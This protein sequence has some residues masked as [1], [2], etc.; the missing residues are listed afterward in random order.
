[1]LD[2]LVHLVDPNYDISLGDPWNKLLDISLDAFVL[3]VTLPAKGSTTQPTVSLSYSPG[4]DLGFLDV[5]TIT[6]TYSKPP[7][8]SGTSSVKIAIEGRF[9]GQPF[10]GNSGNPPLTWDAMN[11][12]PPSIPGKGAQLFD[13]EYVGLGQHVALSGPD[14][15][16]VEKVMA[17]LR[18]SVIPVQAGQLPPFG[19]AGGISFSADS[20]WL[21]G[22]QFTVMDTVAIAGIFNDPNLY[23]ILITLSG[24]KAK[25]FAGLRF[26]ILYRKVTDSIGV[27][28][29]EFTL[30]DEMRH[31]EFGEVSITLPVLVLDIYTNGNF[32]ID[33]GFPTGLDFSNSF[34]IQVFPFLGYGGFYFALLDGATSSRVPQIGN[35]SFSPVIEF[36]IALSLGVGK[37]VDEGILKGG[38]SVTVVGILQGVLGWF[39]PSDSSPKDTY[40]GIQGTVS[41]VG[42]LYATIDFAIIQASVDVTAYISVTLTIESY[43]PIYIEAT[44]SVSVRVSVK[45]VFF[46]I[47]CSFSATVDASFTIGSAGTPPWKVIPGGASPNV[48][49]GRLRGQMTLHSPPPRH[50]RYLK[51]LRRSLASTDP[52]ITTWPALCVLPQGKQTVTIWAMPSFTKSETQRGGV[53]AVLLL[54][55]ENSIHPGA[56][57]LA[58]HR[59]L[60]GVDPASAPFN[61]LME[62][63]LRWGIHVVTSG[64]ANVTADQLEGLRKQLHN[65]DTVAAAFDYATLTQFLAQNFVF[66]IAPSADQVPSATIAPAPSGASRTN[67]ITTVTTT[68][69]HGFA[70]GDTV[71]VS[72]VADA[73]FDGTGPFTIVAPVTSTSLAYQQ[74][75]QPDSTSGGGTVSKAA[76]VAI[77]PM[78]PEI[79]LTDTTGTHVA[80]NGFNMVDT[81]YQAKA[82]AYFQLLQVQF[83][84]LDAAGSGSPSADLLP[85]ADPGVSMATIIFSRYFNMLMSAGVKA[86]I[87]LL[88][89]Y[90]YVIGPAPMSMSDI[91]A[92]LS[93]NLIDDPLQ[94][95]APNQ[96]RAVL[97]AGARLSLP[98][99]MHQVRL[100]ESFATIAAALGAGALDAGGKPYSAAVLIAANLDSPGIFNTG[101]ATWPIAAQTGALRSGGT[102]TIASA[103]PHGLVPGN[104]VWVSGVTDPTFNG[105]YR[106]TAV[107][108][109]TTFAYV[110]T[111]QPDGTSQGGTATTTISVQV[112][113]L[114][115]TSQANETLG[116]IA[117]RLLLRAAGP[118]LIATISGLSEAAQTLLKIPANADIPN[119]NA[120]IDPTKIPAVALPTGPPYVVVAG[121]TLTLVAAY[122]LAIAQKVLNT[123][124]FLQALAQ[125]NPALPIDPSAPLTAGTAIA[126]PP[127]I[128]ECQAGDTIANVAVTLIASASALQAALAEVPGGLPLLAPQAVLKAPLVYEVQPGDTFSGIA[129]RLDLTLEDVA[130]GA[131]QAVAL[132]A[133]NQTVTIADLAKIPVDTL[134][135]GS[136]VGGGQ[137]SGLL[138]QAEWNKAS[139][140]VSRFLLSGLRLPDPNDPVFQALT[141]KDLQDPTK[142]GGI[143]TKPMFALTGQQYPFANSATS[144]NYQITLA[145]PGAASW[146]TF[147]SGASAIFSLTDG[148]SDLLEKIASTPLDPQMQQPERMALFRMV[149]PRM[150]LQNHV[151]WQA[152]VLPPGTLS[153]AGAATGNPSIWLFPDTLA[154][155]IATAATQT[156]SPLIYEL[157]TAKRNVS[158]QA[159]SAS[160]ARFYAW[161][162]IVDLVISLP[163]SDGPAPSL[164]NA[165]ILDGADDI[166]AALLQDVHTYL[167]ETSDSASLYLLYSPNPTSANTNGLVSDRLEPNATCLIKANLSTL[168]HSGGGDFLAFAVTDPTDV[169]AASLGHAADFVA[170]AWEASITRSGGFYL[171]YVNGN[172]GR[173]FPPAV[174]S[175]DTRATV[176]LLILLQSQASNRDAPILPF[177]NCAV[178]GG[179]IDT[180]VTGLFVQPATAIVQQ[181]D[182]L[183]TLQTQFNQ[184]WGTAFT[185][186]D[187]AT[188]NANVPLLL[189]IGA[190]LTIP[191]QADYV[192]QYGDTLAS[193][194][195]NPALHLSDVGALV[196]AGSNAVAAILAPGAQMQFAEGVLRPAATVP[197]GTVGFEIMRTNPDPQNRPYP[198]LDGK[199]LVSQLFNLV[200]FGIAAGG[201]FIASG[202][203]LPTTPADSPQDKSDGLGAPDSDDALAADWYYHQTLTVGPFARSWNGSASQALPSAKWN[204]YNGIGYNVV[205]GQISTVVIN[206][207][208]QDIYG[209]TQ[210]L[211]APFNTVSVPVGYYDALLGLGSWPSLGT[212]WSV[213]DSST[214][215]LVISLNMSLQQA[216]YVPSASVSVASA[217]AAIQA[218][219]A[220]YRRIYYQLAQPDVTFALSTTL[221]ATASAQRDYPLP[222]NLFFSFA[223]GAYI[224]LSAFSTLQA[225]KFTVTDATTSVAAVTDQYGVTAPQLFEANRGQLYSA[226]FPPTPL[227]SV[228]EIYLTITGDSLKSIVD[229]PKFKSYG[230]SAAKLAENNI[231]APVAPGTEFAMPPGNVAPT[232]LLDSPNGAV[233]AQGVATITTATPHGFAVGDAVVIAG[234][235]DDSFNGVFTVS[236]VPQP[237]MFTYAQPTL[238][239]ASSGGGMAGAGTLNAAGRRS[240]ASVAALATANAGRTDILSKG[241]YL[242]VGTQSYQLVENDSFANAATYLATSVVALALA[243]QWVQGLLMG[244]A[245]LKVDTVQAG[246]GDTLAT[247]AAHAGQPPDIFV[248]YDG[249]ASV[250]NLFSSGTP[251]VLRANPHVV[252]PSADDTFIRFA[253]A[254]GVTLDELAAANAGSEALFAQ[255]SVLAIPSAL[256]NSSL[257]QYCTY[258][259]S[260]ADKLSDIAAKFGITPAALVAL[261]PDLPGPG[262]LWICPPMTGGANGGNPAHSLSGLAMAYRTDPL[263]LATANAAA[264]SFLATGSALTL[265]GVPITTKAYETFNS[266]R[267]RV[268]AAHGV[269]LTLADVVAQLQDVAGLIDPAAQVLPVPPPS[270]VG[271]QAEI[272]PSFPSQ[273]FKIAVNVTATRNPDWVDPDFSSVASVSAATFGVPPAMQAGDGAL[274]LADFATTVES[275]LPGL[276]VATGDPSAGQDRKA[277]TAIY[278]VNFG[279]PHGPSI[280][281]QFK[282]TE[283]QFFALPPLSTS[284]AAGRVPVQSYASGQGLVG[285]LISR[286]FQAVDL[287]VW[288]NAF[289]EAV[290]LFLSPAFAVPAYAI[291]PTT[292]TAVISAKQTLAQ[293][294][295]QRIAYILDDQSRGSKADAQAAIYQ[296]LLLRLS[297]AFTVDAIVQVPVQVAYNSGD[298]KAEGPSSAPRLSGKV[299]MNPPDL[300]NV[301]SMSPAKVSLTTTIEPTASFLFSVKAPARHKNLPLNLKYVVTELELPDSNATIGDYE[302]SSWL[303]FVHPLDTAISST[304][305]AI[306]VPIPL[307][308]Y[309]SPVSLISQAARQAVEEPMVATDF[310]PWNFDFAYRH[311]DAEQDTSMVAVTFNDADSSRFASRVGSGADLSG[312][313]NALAQFMSVYTQLKDDLA[314]LPLMPPGSG[315][316]KPSAIYVEAVQTFSKLVV[317][318]ADAFQPSVDFAV[319]SLG[320]EFCYQ[321]QKQ[322]VAGKLDTLTVTS[323]D[324]AGQP[325]PNPNRLW[326]SVSVMVDNKVVPLVA[327][328][329]PTSASAEYAYPPGQLEADQPPAEH[330]VFGDQAALPT[331]FAGAENFTFRNPDIFMRPSGRA[332]VAIARNLSLLGE[333]I[334][335]NPAFVYRTPLTVFPNSVLPSVTGATPIVLGAA[336]TPVRD[337]LA[338]FFQGLF[339]SSSW[340]EG[341]T[342]QIRFGASFS[343]SLA[344]TSTTRE[345]VSSQLTSQVPILLVPLFEFDPTSDV[346]GPESFVGQIDTA[347]AAWVTAYTPPLGRG[348]F[349]FDLTVYASQDE[350]R[351]LMRASNLE[352]SLTPVRP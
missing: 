305:A 165:Y 237:A 12:R 137:S 323:V 245:S 5:D 169:Y 233:R 108:S 180:T 119:S 351:A 192:I 159:A 106:V 217:L 29:I 64:S 46:T 172:G 204:P 87:D 335:T 11:E 290:D 45:I 338:A 182:S 175:K 113:G 117:M 327:V 6:L 186:I 270:P 14:L 149:P 216:R 72:G 62:A 291:D 259:A 223:Y 136:S 326:P 123:D 283:T 308:S 102:T 349:V 43:Q 287:D 104:L 15:T 339:S 268:A 83:D 4:P 295:S 196:A 118:A 316:A 115:H 271:N 310:L 53:E 318:V 240:K 144:N 40:Y 284:L 334:P 177:N 38:I 179:N 190:S 90:P 127:V 288:L 141:L 148:E 296:A 157:V 289:L 218:D 128:R 50:A 313:F 293:V 278:G 42:K 242:T 60:S 199:A 89:E 129:A 348:S 7:A 95:V 281:Y 3:T 44:A 176:S 195:A 249:N 251:I 71:V 166:G 247:L 294:L 170:L 265:G 189:R 260:S 276:R 282:W 101:T 54:T 16:T 336:P 224:Y 139:G 86:A 73:S 207:S 93:T 183:S 10:G 346:Y 234:V 59:L 156:A 81:N 164:A 31:L 324:A 314:L 77:F 307:R 125:F 298:G 21:I 238:P 91:D 203:G 63:M 66:R 80:F 220:S 253:R 173:G 138:G 107:P 212:T 78:I 331:P 184:D 329:I 210:T 197:P 61:L 155:Q 76:G 26:E 243:N 37:T 97:A 226:V 211:A 250:A 163:E 140:M 58:D 150:P 85:A 22:A 130:D 325:V 302:G 332:A 98:E 347:L 230:L 333:S 277:L 174:F 122:F 147:A 319:A 321:M 236:S 311:M 225:V 51:A 143:A 222:S 49:A 255:G 261:N 158:D 267:V 100:E 2:H 52:P 65:D 227:L 201:G 280:S 215:G 116:L 248:A 24:E 232:A 70:V 272:T 244:R 301:F 133:A 343:F 340:T 214:A 111:G 94:I 55:A 229:N 231:G 131:S 206:L 35:G 160:Q 264:I 167:Q 48:L 88:A 312:A 193:I 274:G 279:S 20:N 27:Y 168:T 258:S 161:A 208:A 344:E 41:V 47:H 187:V 254:N 292:V 99:V 273:V 18:N 34:S 28:H 317:A 285:D 181:G 1:M 269:V 154:A 110:Q 309:P 75:G 263:T 126:L 79:L 114:T 352:Y 235:A 112:S 13:L 209:N 39:H 337:A 103:A 8:G 341:S 96:S 69:A 241:V 275:V 145:N 221:D 92:A 32:R 200:G 132:F 124:T 266:L 57:T 74:P 228:P 219:L 306:N 345:P 25:I 9:L 33:L 246:A 328:G 105:A 303:R 330:F 185:V 84:A 342:V 322:S 17:A 297:S 67:G 82:R 315:T 299:V 178:V 151:A 188:A 36:G 350:N 198:Q 257:A 56:A 304:G 286:N 252:P 30:P 121:D 135:G 171:N 191:G 142:L 162:T 152:A 109:A 202:T 256:A 239:A 194:V 153:G 146:V 23:G 300:E 262:G 320:W 205:A 134:I 120:P 213:A 19:Q 68:A